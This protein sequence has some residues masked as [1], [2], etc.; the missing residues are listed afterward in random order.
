MS[1]SLWVWG[2]KARSSWGGSMGWQGDRICSGRRF[3]I[4]IT[5]LC[6][7]LSHLCVNYE[8]WGRS[9]LRR[10]LA[11]P[12]TPIDLYSD[13]LMLEG[14]HLHFQANTFCQ[15]LG[16]STILR[17]LWWKLSHFLAELPSNTGWVKDFLN[18]F[19]N[20]AGRN[21][22][23]ASAQANALPFSKLITKESFEP[24]S[25]K[26]CRDWLKANEH[27]DKNSI[28]NDWKSFI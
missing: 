10:K 14:T 17:S 21:E 11:H 8:K 5:F 19:K 20:T 4:F 9:V 15:V 25:G 2:I 16:K 13:H 18:S 7:P 1:L 12:V 27:C 6:L 24:S 3:G 26:E 28:P 22:K 23:K